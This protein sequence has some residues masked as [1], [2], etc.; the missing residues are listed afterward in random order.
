M[1]KGFN[2]KQNAGWGE[3]KGENLGQLSSIKYNLKI[4]Q[5][6]TARW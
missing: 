2:K 5:V 4:E 6:E 1:R 3:A